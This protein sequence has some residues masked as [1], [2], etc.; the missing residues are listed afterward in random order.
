MKTT[1]NEENKVEEQWHKRLLLKWPFTGKYLR[2]Q[3]YY[4]P[5]S[6]KNKTMYVLWEWD[7]FVPITKD[8]YEK[9]LE[10]T[11]KVA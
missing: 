1:T 9:W 10:Y 6:Q 7:V 2:K 8:S 11:A 4:D 5:Q 3:R